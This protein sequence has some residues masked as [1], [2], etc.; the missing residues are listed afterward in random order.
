MQTSLY[1]LVNV[2]TQFAV[3]AHARAFVRDSQPEKS[4]CS[5]IGEYVSCQTCLEQSIFIIPAQIFK[6]SVRNKSAVSEQSVSTQRAIR[7]QSE[8]YQ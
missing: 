2:N 3:S 4:R 6:H 7:E 8:K 5:T 1:C